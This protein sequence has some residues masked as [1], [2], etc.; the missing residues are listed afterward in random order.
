MK[1]LSNYIE[2][3]DFSEPIICLMNHYSDKELRQITYYRYFDKWNTE[4]LESLSR[5]ELKKIIDGNYLIVLWTIK[6]LE[7][8]IN[9][10]ERK[11]T[12]IV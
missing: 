6:Q 2:R 12:K 3:D 10:E 7:E 1:K 4:E 5:S 9:S 11:K 8:D